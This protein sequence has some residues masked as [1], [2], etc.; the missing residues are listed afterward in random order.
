MEKVI[1]ATFSLINYEF[2]DVK[3]LGEN[4]PATESLSINFSTEGGYNEED[5]LFNLKFTTYVSE[6]GKNPYISVLCTAQYRFVEHIKLAEIPDYFYANSIAILFPY[7]RAYISFLTTQANQRAVIL[8]TY[9]LSVLGSEL[10][11]N[12]TTNNAEH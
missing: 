3:M 12:T 10:Q 9:N 2:I 1:N 4:R 8:P 7:V 11:K 5:G 6:E